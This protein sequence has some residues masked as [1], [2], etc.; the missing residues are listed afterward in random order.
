MHTAT[1]LHS[2]FFINI[3]NHYAI[4]YIQHIQFDNIY[5]LCVPVHRQ[6]LVLT[7]SHR[8]S[9]YSTGLSFPHTHLPLI[10]IATQHRPVLPPYAHATHSYCYTAPACPSPIRACHSLIL[11]YNCCNVL[12][13]STGN[14]STNFNHNGNIICLLKPYSFLL[15]I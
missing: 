2:R 4:L 14:T 7:N 10:H 5:S 1:T 11:L 3:N 6:T 8:I 9:S 12:S 13:N 15:N